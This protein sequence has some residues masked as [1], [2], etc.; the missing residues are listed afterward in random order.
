MCTNGCTKK[1]YKDNLLCKKHYID[2]SLTETTKKDP[3]GNLLKFCIKCNKFEL[4]SGFRTTAGK[5]ATKCTTCLQKARAVED[6]RRGTRV[7]TEVSKDYEKRPEVIARR[8]AYRDANPDI[9]SEATHK[10]RRIQKEEN[11]ETYLLRNAQNAK[12]LRDKKK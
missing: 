7:Q 1:N 8:Q 9:Y 10:Y 2:K 6:K 12:N 3:E 5:V 4:E 11:K